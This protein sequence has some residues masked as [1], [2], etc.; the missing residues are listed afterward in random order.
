M[1]SGV[2]DAKISDHLPIVL[3]MNVR[4]NHNLHEL[5][6]RDHCYEN[7]CKLRN[8]ISAWHNDF[9]IADDIDVNHTADIFCNTLFSIYNECCPI[10]RKRISFKR[11]SKPWLSGNLMRLIN[12]KHEL[13]R[14]FRRGDVSFYEYKTLE[15]QLTRS[16][17]TAKQ[18]YFQYKFQSCLGN[19]KNTWRTIN[20]LIKN[21]I[22][23]NN[24]ERI[25][26]NSEFIIDKNIIASSFNS[27]FSTIGS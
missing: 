4:P 9:N 1:K 27:Y 19:T 5:V 13:F 23:T 18:Q 15:K 24:V 14:S 10:R 3:T 21:K 16:L 20:S 26:V 6:F 25:E 17:R 11:L 7:L 8:M 2:I 22:N 12:R